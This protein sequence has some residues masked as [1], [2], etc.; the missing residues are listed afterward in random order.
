[1]PHCT[2]VAA[3]TTIVERDP[4]VVV[5]GIW[6]VLSLPVTPLPPHSERKDPPNIPSVHADTHTPRPHIPQKAEEQLPLPKYTPGARL[7]FP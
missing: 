5:A 7:P 4:A 6:N 3:S 1:M 2:E